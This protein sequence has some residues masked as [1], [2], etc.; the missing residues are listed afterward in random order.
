[1]ECSFPIPQSG[2][3]AEVRID[4]GDNLYQSIIRLN[5]VG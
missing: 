2:H 1:M 5:A 3:I 4:N